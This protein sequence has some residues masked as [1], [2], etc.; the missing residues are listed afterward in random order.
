M[1]NFLM[2]LF[3]VA[4]FFLPAVLIFWLLSKDR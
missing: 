2:F 4:V 1:N 3:F